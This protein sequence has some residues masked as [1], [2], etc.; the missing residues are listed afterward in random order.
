VPFAATAAGCTPAAGVGHERMTPMARWLSLDDL[1]G[2]EVA[3]IAFV[4]DYVEVNFDGPILRSIASPTIEVAGKRL[5][6]PEEGSRDALCGLIGQTV[7]VVE[8]RSDAIL[9]AFGA[10]Q[11]RIPRAD[12]SIGAEVAHF[13]P[14]D[15][16]LRVDLMRIWMN[17]AS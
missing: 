7:V 15:R 10:A 14:W 3:S 5:T 11:L 2:A 6:F 1:K 12:P 17:Q 13:V 8:E 16:A 9:V 4:R